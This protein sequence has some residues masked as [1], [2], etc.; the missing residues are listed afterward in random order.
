M[1]ELY[2]VISLMK[3]HYHL[4]P[5]MNL[6]NAR[7]RPKPPPQSHVITPNQHPLYLGRSTPHSQSKHLEEILIAFQKSIPYFSNRILRLIPLQPL[8]SPQP[9]SL[10]PTTPKDDLTTFTF[11]FNQTAKVTLQVRLK[12][13]PFT[14]P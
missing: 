9:F 3:H 12:R 7:T 8:K 6:L 11:I 4:N 2:A 1:D 10:P 13:S 5:P 14:T